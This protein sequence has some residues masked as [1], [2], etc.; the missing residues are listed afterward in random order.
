MDQRIETAIY[1]KLNLLSREGTLAIKGYPA[2]EIIILDAAGRMQ[3]QPLAGAPPEE[4]ANYLHEYLRLLGAFSSIDEVCLI[5]DCYA[6]SGGETIL[7]DVLV[8]LHGCAKCSSKIGIVE[9][10][11]RSAPV[12]TKPINWQNSFWRRTMTP[13]GQEV[14]NGILPTGSWTGL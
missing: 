2:P 14:F 7:P 10:D 8:I 1:T 12:V 9:Y 6:E 3:T 4:A 5:L 13:L 11:A